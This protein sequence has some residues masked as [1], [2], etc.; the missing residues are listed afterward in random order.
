[1]TTGTAQTGD[2][3]TGSKGTEG[4]EGESQ[5]LEAADV[6]TLTQQLKSEKDARRAAQGRLADMEVK[7]QSFDGIETVKPPVPEMRVV[8]G[9]FADGQRHL[10]AAEWKQR[11]AAC[12]G[13][14]PHL[15]ENVVGGQE[16]F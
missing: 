1:M 9:V 11:L 12:R 4:A 16:H 15:I 7:L 14:I 13:K 8:P 2:G 5:P 3:S 6:A 10:L